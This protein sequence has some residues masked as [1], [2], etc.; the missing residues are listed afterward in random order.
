MGKRLLAH[1]LLVLC[2]AVD[3]QTANGD[4]K[5]GLAGESAED[6]DT[7]G[8]L[9]RSRGRFMSIKA[10]EL[11]TCA[12]CYKYMPGNQF[13]DGGK[14]NLAGFPNYFVEG[15]PVPRLV[16][17]NGTDVVRGCSW[18]SMLL[19]HQKIART[20]WLLCRVAA[21]SGLLQ[22]FRNVNDVFMQCE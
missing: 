19:L 14:W 3:S 12:M 9:C 20:S 6:E 17:T 21:W 15:Y 7:S 5:R 22:R 4:A 18:P 13:V 16:D 8:Y 11:E 2:G 1:F 10:F